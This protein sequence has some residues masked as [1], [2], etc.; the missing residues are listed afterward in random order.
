MPE[1]KS[2]FG[3]YHEMAHIWARI[4]AIGQVFR[5]VLSEPEASTMQKI[6]LIGYFNLCLFIYIYFLLFKGNNPNRI[7]RAREKI[8][9][10]ISQFCRKM[11]AYILKFSCAKRFKD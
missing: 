8:S 2:F 4:Q 9:T 6:N 10:T 3:D 11:I 1:S 7:S 5:F